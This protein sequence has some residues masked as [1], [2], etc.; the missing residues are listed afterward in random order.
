V[1]SGIRLPASI[2]TV[3]RVLSVPRTQRG[4]IL[5]LDYT[6]ARYRGTRDGNVP[7]RA[8]DGVTGRIGV[9]Y[10]MYSPEGFRRKVFRS[11]IR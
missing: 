1:A 7:Q 6:P 5:T 10:C 4:A 9:D 3:L 2:G 11:G 8:K